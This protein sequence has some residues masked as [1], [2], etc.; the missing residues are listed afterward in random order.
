MAGFERQ[1]L[2]WIIASADAV[3]RARLRATECPQC[4]KDAMRFDRI[5]CLRAK[6][7]LPRNLIFERRQAET[8]P[9]PMKANGA[10]S[11]T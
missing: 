1:V 8:E 7:V 3:T 4:A 9:K 5:K 10:Y 2:R 11:G 6:G